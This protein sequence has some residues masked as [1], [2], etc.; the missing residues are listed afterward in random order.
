MVCSPT[1]RGDR[2]K[3]NLN[4]LDFNYDTPPGAFYFSV[5]AGSAGLAGSAVEQ[6]PADE[7][8]C[9]V[10]RSDANGENSV[11]FS[12]AQL[13]LAPGDNVD[14]LVVRGSTTVTEIWFSVDEG[15]AGLPGTAVAM[16]SGLGTQ[17]GDVFRSPG[18]MQNTLII[19]EV[20]LGLQAQDDLDALAVVDLSFIEYLT[21]VPPWG[22]DDDL[23]PFGQQ[24]VNGEKTIYEY[25]AGFTTMHPCNSMCGG[26][27]A[28]FGDVDTLSTPPPEA[29]IRRT[30][31]FSYNPDPVEFELLVGAQSPLSLGGTSPGCPDC[32]VHSDACQFQFYQIDL[33]NARPVH[34]AVTITALNAPR[35]A[36][37][38]PQSELIHAYRFR[39]STR[40]PYDA[41]QGGFPSCDLFQGATDVAV[42]RNTP[43][44]REFETSR[45]EGPNVSPGVLPTCGI[46]TQ[47]F[48]VTVVADSRSVDL[49]YGGC[50]DPENPGA[51]E[52]CRQGDTSEDNDDDCD[53]SVDEGCPCTESR[54]CTRQD[55]NLGVNETCLNGTQACVGGVFG[56]CELNPN[57]ATGVEVRQAFFGHQGN[58]GF[59]GEEYTLTV[60]PRTLGELVP[61][62]C[63]STSN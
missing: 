58:R 45:V 1:R 21:V 2:R 46:S 52:V 61:T 12:C 39:D 50:A 27:P 56:P 22:D 26:C 30:Q 32:V 20:A 11:A 53:F 47:N 16:E 42:L 25:P 38:L 23:P 49:T 19:P 10:F 43:G 48:F 14:A 63:R 6:T 59:R 24:I 41:T 33:R 51:E 15:S 9:T 44:G 31:S 28:P 8:A 3:D 34:L 29:Q 5:A 40:P 18:T 57:P 36:S 17:A 4:A 37:S 62:T 54:A 7:R 35:S 13:G 55:T 60:H